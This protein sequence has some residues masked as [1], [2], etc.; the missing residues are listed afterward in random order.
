MPC[1]QTPRPSRFSATLSP[2]RAA[3]RSPESRC[4]RPGAGRPGCS[5]LKWTKGSSHRPAAP[6]T[7]SVRSAKQG[8]KSAETPPWSEPGYMGAAVSSM[9][10]T[11]QAAV[12]AGIFT[13][14]GAGTVF[15]CSVIGPTIAT[16]IPDLFAFSKTTWP[17]LGVTY[18]AAGIAHF[19]LEQGFLDM[20]PHRGAWGIYF[21]PGSPSF[22]VQWTGEHDESYV[23]HA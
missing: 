10:E 14:L 12:V 2:S 17:I 20:Y 8:G 21:L 3:A 18:V 1:C 11:T 4:A 19:G 9:P 22:H 15:G 6:R 5:P 16:A 7:V 23:A 13:A